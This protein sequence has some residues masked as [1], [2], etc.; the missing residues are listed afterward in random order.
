MAVAVVIQREAPVRARHELRDA[1]RPGV[2][3][4]DAQ[5]VDA[6]LAREDQIVFELRPEE[7]GALG[8]VERERGQRVDHSVGPDVAAVKG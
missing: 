7:I 6:H 4:L 2:G 5:R 3:A 1:D 8:I